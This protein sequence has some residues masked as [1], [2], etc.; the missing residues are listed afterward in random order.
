MWANFRALVGIFSQSIGPSLAIWADPVQLSSCAAEIFHP[1]ACGGASMGA[2]G[3][4]HAWCNYTHMQGD[5][6]PGR[7]C[8][9]VAILI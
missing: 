1:D 2:Q 9:Y 6:G 8:H 5:D 3:H 7:V 4:P